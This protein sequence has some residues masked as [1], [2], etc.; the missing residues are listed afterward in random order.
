MFSWKAFQNVLF[1]WKSFHQVFSIYICRQWPMHG[2]KVGTN[3]YCRCQ[4]LYSEC[5]NSLQMAMHWW[6][7]WERIQW[8]SEAGEQAHGGKQRFRKGAWVKGLPFGP[9]L[10]WLN[11]IQLEFP[12]NQAVGPDDI[13]HAIAK[14]VGSG[15][16][17][18]WGSILALLL[19]AHR[20]GANLFNHFVL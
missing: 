15:A 14:P 10:P 3:W 6:E 4:G 7:K 17:L 9:Y 19:L 18:P 13:G 2:L 12:R 1:I 11:I 8:H 20:F 16:G 5:V